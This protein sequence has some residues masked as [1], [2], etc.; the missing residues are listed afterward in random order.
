MMM[1]IIGHKYIFRKMWPRER[2]KRA[3]VLPA[4]VR[5]GKAAGEVHGVKAITSSNSIY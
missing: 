5:R 1:M 3:C 4:R 2:V